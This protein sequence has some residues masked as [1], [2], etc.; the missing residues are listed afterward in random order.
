MPSAAPDECREPSP[1]L[2]WLCQLL[3]LAARTLGGTG[4]AHTG[5]LLSEFSGAPARGEH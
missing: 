5:C 4:R 3:L 2:L 1:A